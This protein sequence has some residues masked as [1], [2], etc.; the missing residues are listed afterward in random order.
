MVADELEKLFNE[1]RHQVSVD[2][3]KTN[4]FDL[5][6]E[7]DRLKRSYL[8]VREQVQFLQF[9]IVLICFLLALSV[10]VNLGVPSIFR[11]FSIHFLSVASS[12]PSTRPASAQQRPGIRQEQAVAG[13]CAGGRTR[14]SARTAGRRGGI[15]ASQFFCRYGVSV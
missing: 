3:D 7:V 4:V 13:H 15:P 11:R 2:P 1:N 9:L 5:N 8:D 14:P 6:S 12:V 10:I